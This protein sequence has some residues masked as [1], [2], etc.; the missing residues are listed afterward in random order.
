MHFSPRLTLIVAIGLLT[1]LQPLSASVVRAG[2]GAGEEPLQ[3]GLTLRVGTLGDISTTNVFGYKISPNGWTANVLDPL[4]DG[5]LQTDPDTDQLLP[6]IA[7]GVDADESGQLEQDEVGVFAK[8]A[9]TDQWTVTV[10]YDLNG[11]KFHDGTQATVEDLLFSYHATTKIP[12]VISNDV[13][14]DQAGQ[15]GSNYTTTRWLH[16]Y[17]MDNLNVWGDEG[18]GTPSTDPLRG[19]LQFRLQGDYYAFYSNTVNVRLYPRYVWEGTGS[20]VTW[21]N[22][23]SR[24]DGQTVNCAHADWGNALDTVTW[25]GVP[26]TSGGA[27]DLSAA[28]AW[29]VPDGCVIGTGPFVWNQ[30]I[31]A[32]STEIDR[33]PQFFT[34]TDAAGYEYIHP[35]FMDGMVFTIYATV[36][37]AVVALEANQIDVIAAPIPAD[38]AAGLQGNPDITLATSAER[39]F[40]YLGYH[41]RIPG[42]APWSYQDGDPT[43]PD[44]GFIFRQAVAHTI[45]KQTMVTVLLQNFGVA[46]DGVVSPVLTRWYNTSLPP[47]S[48]DLVM[49]TALLDTF[50]T[51]PAGPCQVDGTGCRSFVGIGTSLFDIQCPNAGYDPVRAAACVMIASDMRQV[52]INVEAMPLDF[53]QLVQNLDN[54]DIRMWI[55]AWRIGSEPP[56]YMDAFF[57]SG[58]YP[59]GQNYPGYA[60]PVFDQLITDVQANMDPTSQEDQVKYA[61][62]ILSTD[63]PYDVLYYRTNIE[64]YRNDRTTNWT[65]GPASS[66]FQGSYWSWIGVRPPDAVPAAS[67]LGVDG[68]LDGTPGI[69]HITSAVPVLNWTYSDPQADPQAEYEVRVGTGPG[70]SDSWAP[71]VKTGSVNALVYGGSA[72]LDGATYY[73]GVRVSDGG[74]WSGWT[75]VAFHTNAAVTPALTSPPDGATDLAA[76]TLMLNWSAT[77]DPEGDAITYFW[78]L[79]TISDFSAL[80]DS[81]TSV[82][83]TT[84]VTVVEDTQYFW[85][86]QT[87]DGWEMSLNSTT[88]LFTTASTPPSNGTISGVVVGSEGNPIEG[89]TVELRDAGGS[90]VAAVTTAADGTF[91]FLG[92]AFGTYTVDVSAPGFFDAAV[93]DVA[94]SVSSPSA[95]V[96]AVTMTAIPNTPPSADHLGTDGFSPE[97]PEALHILSTRP[98]LNWTYADSDGDPQAA[99]EVRVGTAPGTDDMWAPGVQWTSQSAVTYDG[100]ALAR[101]EDYYWSVRVFDGTVWS[102]WVEV[103]F[104]TNAP[105]PTP[106]PSVPAHNNAS[107]APGV[108]TLAWQGVTDSDG[109]AVEYLWAVSTTPDFS[110][111]ADSGMTASS[112]AETTVEPD[113]EYYWRVAAW[114]GWEFGENSTISRFSVTEE[115]PAVDETAP[116]SAW[117]WAVPVAVIV[118]AFLALWFLLK[119]RKGPAEAAGERTES[120]A[121]HEDVEP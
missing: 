69:L 55:I 78:Y 71:G 65:V 106:I 48:Y 25:N 101:G 17:K 89:A 45:D 20:L 19:A 42:G 8:E 4:Y 118:V 91:V 62:G 109:D 56:D 86:V 52:G 110:I 1:A 50:S 27:W 36:T 51:D 77:A 32:V 79:A 88:F 2:T 22:P 14:K 83:N 103:R 119:R 41:M 114:D 26:E 37:A 24:F 61:Q 80:A 93:E 99:F 59:S 76:G 66:I 84:A 54:R 28:T 9:G 57:Y 10:Y 18:T 60:N 5:V 104:H 30:R 44:I 29:T 96:G 105:P 3:S 46:G 35:P 116:L 53:A 100:A 90:V 111:V 21:S 7:R 73:F 75:E 121:A 39:G 87:W 58:N 33:N 98:T 38:Q 82:T 6:Y 74:N 120:E 97:S 68:F 43:Q 11:V 13:I 23:G 34:T 63:L 112:W 72:L 47:Y 108:V 15:P 102:P 40:A 117:L 113:T 16:L 81:G 95:Y 85:R 12:T 64:A 115:P 94:I 70:L 31:A 92:V 107:V 49:A 67:F